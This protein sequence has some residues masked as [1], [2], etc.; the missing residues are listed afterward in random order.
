MLLAFAGMTLCA[1]A[2][3]PDHSETQRVYLSGHGCDD[4][5][6]W[7]F[8]CTGGA[9]CGK[10]GRIAVPSCWELQGYGTYQ[11]GFDFARKAFP[12]G[13]ANERG[14]YRRTFS[15]PS[16]WRGGHVEMVFE[17]V[18]TDA[19]VSLNGES[20]GPPHRGAFYRFSYDVSALLRYGR[21]NTVEVTVSKESADSTINLAQRR[22]DYWNFGG[23]FRPVYLE[24]KP[25]A[26]IDRVAIDA[27]AEGLFTAECHVTGA[28]DGAVKRV[29]ISGQDGEEAGEG[30]VPAGEL[31]IVCK[32]SD[33]ALWN[34]E[35]PNLYTAEFQLCDADG[36]VLH[37]HRQ[38][39]GF[40]TVETR[41][42]DGVYVNGVK[43]EVR[44]VDRHCFRPETGR[45]LSPRLN[46][47]DALAIRG[48]NMN[49]VRCSH[50]PPDTDFLDI[51][52]SL[53]LYVID[54]FNGWQ[55]AVSAEAGAP[56]VREMVTRD[57][58]HPCILWWANGNE[59]GFNF[60]LEPL[61]RKYDPQQRPVL[62][63]WLRHGGYETKHY[64][65]YGALLELLREPEV[66]MPT[67]YL[68]GLY[69]GGHGAGLEDFW[70]AIHSAPNG[71]GGFLWSLA[72]EG[73][74]RRDLADSIDC[75]GDKA[76]DGILGPH[77][78]REGSWYTIRQLWSPVQVTLDGKLGKDGG[79]LAVE[80]RYN[81]LNLSSCS[82]ALSY[83]AITDYKET[84]LFETSLQGPDV[85]PGETG[86]I[87]AP[88][89][90]DEADAL[91][92]TAC[93]D[94]GEELFTWSFPLP[95]RPREFNAVRPEVSEDGGL[96]RVSAGGVAWTFDGATGLLSG[97]VADGRT[98]SLSGGP[99][100]VA[101]RRAD[102]TVDGNLKPLKRNAPEHVR[103]D[104]VADSSVF[105]GFGM[106]GD[107]LVARWSRGA[108]RETRW[109][110]SDD[111]SAKIDYCYRYDGLVD[112]MGV[113]FE[114]PEDLV[115]SKR[116]VGD[117][118]CRVWQNRLKGPRFGA[119]EQEYNNAIPGEVFAYPEFKGYFS[120]VRDVEFETGE[121]ALSL[122]VP[123]G[124]W[125][126]VYTPVDGRTLNLYVLP[127]TGLGVFDV[128]PAVR[129]KFHSTD[130]LGQHSRPAWAS[131]MY[132]GSII[133][134]P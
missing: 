24:R 91:L 104:L 5:V 111:G 2:P 64:P 55:Q 99:R 85:A 129:T 74:V 15:V 126:G 48:M 71:A 112:L 77:G 110:F 116:W 50:Y 119:W 6:E 115:K 120:G 37:R 8:Y 30:S 113:M 96:L 62:Y 128:I 20:A 43:I 13:I 81:F 12:E 27:R 38:K 40:R 9:N 122:G 68:H 114:Y 35:T 92:V 41:P 3:R 101:A 11:Y 133:L 36:N 17:G 94:R 53:G 98:V 72:D 75:H 70:E 86:C 87:T 28:P 134:N 56:L 88:P 31:T 10:W 80:N 7:D 57:V 52:D 47:E 63:P 29:V 21:R 49:A 127:Q 19:A 124:K 14:L 79:S 103:Y 78:E 100:F 1:A 131:G 65:T 16:S 34:A 69:D 130:E 23:I 39:F 46:L 26:H 105:A 95:R 90:P 42:G 132:S 51:C 123:E 67:E 54:E 108:M 125:L 66:V 109:A 60:E 118:P 45:T 25:A 4:A 121:G 33:P 117:G 58:N 93:D 82:L 107:E 61:Y 97:I 59:G 32:V 89:A 44:G 83:I 18:M 22:G 73:V 76:P 106:E 102:R 84:I